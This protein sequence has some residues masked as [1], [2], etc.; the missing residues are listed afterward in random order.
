MG[1]VLYI[2]LG[3]LVGLL[4]FG[5]IGGVA[6]AITGGGREDRSLVANGGIGLLGS[7]IGGILWALFS[8][9]EFQLSFGGLVASL[10]GAVALLLTVKAVRRRRSEVRTE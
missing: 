1:I 10:L 8:E 4:W 6:G 7:L 5:F 2:V 9:Q 3:V